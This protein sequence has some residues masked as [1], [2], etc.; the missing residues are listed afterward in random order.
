MHISYK[1]TENDALEATGTKA[2]LIIADTV[3]WVLSAIEMF[4]QQRLTL[5][6]N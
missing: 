1:L 6:C 5:P 3:T 4:Q 2:I